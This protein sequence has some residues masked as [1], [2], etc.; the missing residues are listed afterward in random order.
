[1]DPASLHRWF[2][3]CL[4]RAG[5]PSTVKLHELRHTAADTLYRHKH[6][7]VMAQDRLGHESPTPTRRYLHPSREDLAAAMRDLELSWRNE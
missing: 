4:Q 6:D 5:L 2:K 7:L 3:R 1:M